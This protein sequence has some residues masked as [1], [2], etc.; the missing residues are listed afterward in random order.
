LTLSSARTSHGD[1]PPGRNR[2]PTHA[3]APAG[4][5]FAAASFQSLEKP[6]PNFPMSGKTTLK[7]SNPWK[8]FFQRL[9]KRTPFFPMLGKTDRKISN[10]WKKAA[11]F[12]QPS[13][14][15]YPESAFGIS[16]RSVAAKP[17][18]EFFQPLENESLIFP[19]LGKSFANYSKVWTSGPEIFQRSERRS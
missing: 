16:E 11:G 1:D 7:S 2:K 3:Q 5:R 10:V 13:D 12:F 9:E 15:R 8:E 14:L 19:G 17:E 6:V 18:P 4:P